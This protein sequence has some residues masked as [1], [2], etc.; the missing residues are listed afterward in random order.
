MGKARLGRL[1]LEMPSSL[2]NRPSDVPGKTI[3]F[4]P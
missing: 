2:S 1:N 3:R 4:R